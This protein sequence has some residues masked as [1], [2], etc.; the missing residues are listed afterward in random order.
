MK[1]LKSIVIAT[2]VLLFSVPAWSAEEVNVYSARKE[3]LIKPLLD[4]FSQSTGIRVNLITAG[5]DELIKRLQTEGRNSPADILLTV[6][7]GLL[8]CRHLRSSGAFLYHPWYCPLCRHLILTSY[9]G[10]T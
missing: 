5:A 10:I 7:A 1:I 3:N 9:S 2:V 8:R 4:Q 6:D